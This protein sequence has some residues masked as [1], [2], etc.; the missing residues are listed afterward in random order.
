MTLLKVTELKKEL[1]ELNE[2]EL[3]QI[4]AELYKMNK[5]VQH[6]LSNKFG[7]EAA[8]EDLYEKTKKKI[9]D[10]FFPDR[11]FGKM[12]LGEAKKAITNFKKLSSDTVRTIDLMLYYVELGT[13]FT[14]TNG[15]IDE[16]FYDS[17]NS[18]YDKVI[19]E[20]NKNEEYY[21]IFKDRLYGVIKD[22]SG[23]GWGYHDALC[24]SYYALDW[25]DDEDETLE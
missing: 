21:K 16:R 18:T 4:I 22:S 20:C 8:I 11:G 1:K 25:L 6:Y 15:D 5:D 9:K 24:D 13:E 17:M 12:R 23:L 2:K 14:N 19:E 10:E 3:I 7:G